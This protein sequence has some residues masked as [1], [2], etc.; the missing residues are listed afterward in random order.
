MSDLI[1][2]KSGI[3]AVYKPKSIL[4]GDVV[5][6]VKQILTHLRQKHEQT[7]NQ[8]Q[9]NARNKYGYNRKRKRADQQ[10]DMPTVESLQQFDASPESS[11]V[12]VQKKRVYWP[13]GDLK[14]GHGGTLDPMACGVLIVGI[15]KGT[16]LLNQFLNGDACKKTYIADIKFGTATDTYDSS[17]STTETKSFD[18]ITKDAIESALKKHFAGDI[19]Q[20]PPIYSSLKVDGKRMHAIARDQSTEESK[21]LIQDTLDSILARPVHIFQSKLLSFDSEYGTCKIEVECGGGTYIRSIVHDLGHLLDSCAH[22]TGLE[23]TQQGPFNTSGDS[24]LRLE[25]LLDLAKFDLYM[26]DESIQEKVGEYFETLRI[27]SDKNPSEEVKS[28]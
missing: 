22:M 21:R 25:D 8:L 12:A 20:K 15:N 16:K 4:S 17:G 13:Y 7:D 3:L 14:V 10:F 9:D 18:H 24:V 23:R 28:E 2:K 1:F 11:T 27:T 19:M 5:N 6:F 26:S